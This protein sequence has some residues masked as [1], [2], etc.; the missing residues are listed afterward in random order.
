MSPRPLLLALALFAIP[1]F[2]DDPD[3]PDVIS[4]SAWKNAPPFQHDVFTFV[5]LRPHDHY[6]WYIDRPDSELNFSSR[7]HQLTSIRVDT[8]ARAIDID[9]PDLVNW[10]FVYIVEPGVMHLDDR[11]VEILR[12][13]LLNGACLLLDDFW[14]GEEWQNVTDNL[15]RIFP[16]RAPVPLE[17][18]HPIFHVVFDLEGKPQI[19][20]IDIANANRLTGIFWERD[21]ARGAKYYAIFDDRGRMMVVICRDT[22]LGDGWEREGDNEWFFHQF[23]EKLGYPMGINILTYL[24]TH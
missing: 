20:S 12:R 1:V 16:D 6:R 7:V 5:R 24:M 11:E 4:N 22:D 15:K 23:S 14:G 21:D 13:H 10:P 8:E 9:N 3:A 19:P 17:L 18:D 2:A